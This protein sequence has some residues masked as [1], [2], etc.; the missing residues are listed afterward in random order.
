MT[1]F[2]YL[3]VLVSIFIGLGITHLLFWT[4]RTFS[5]AP[6]TSVGG[7]LLL[8]GRRL[9]SVLELACNRRLTT[10][11]KEWARQKSTARNPKLLRGRVSDAAGCRLPERLQE[12]CSMTTSEFCGSARCRPAA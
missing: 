11:N 2:E 1:A 7:P 4:G 3:T 12:E 6:R 9:G 10:S 8:H 5:V